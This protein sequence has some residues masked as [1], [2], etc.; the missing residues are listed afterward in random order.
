MSVVLAP[1]HVRT[2]F[3]PAEF[4]VQRSLS[5]AA[6]GLG[7]LA[8][9]AWTGFLTYFFGTFAIGFHPRLCPNINTHRL[10]CVF[11]PL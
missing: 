10:R 7:I 5:F 4:R 6:V 11:A 3:R 2:S 1:G 9:V 8:T